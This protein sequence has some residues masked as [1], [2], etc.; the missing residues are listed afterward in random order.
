MRGRSAPMARA[1]NMQYAME[2]PNCR[3]HGYHRATW[4]ARN[5]SVAIYNLASLA[6]NVLTSLPVE[7]RCRSCGFRF[8][9]RPPGKRSFDEC[10]GCGYSLTGNVSGRCPECGWKL[11]RRWHEYRCRADAH[12]KQQN[13]DAALN[14]RSSKDVE[15]E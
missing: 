10:P 6:A 8:T 12:A 7:R 14:E 1:M 9:A 13:K 15:D 5:I 2:C 11:P 4:T 3:S